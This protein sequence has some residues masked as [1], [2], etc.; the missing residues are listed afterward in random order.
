MPEDA[1]AQ[2]LRLRRLNEEQVAELLTCEETKE[3]LAF[4]SKKVKATMNVADEPVLE[5]TKRQ[6]MLY[7]RDAF[8][9]FVFFGLLDNSIMLICGD[10]FDYHLGLMFGISTLTAAALGNIVGDCAGIWL[11]G[12]VEAVVAKLRL[13]EHGF[14][15]EQRRITKAQLIKSVGMTSGILVG[16]VLGMFPLIWPEEL[17]LWS[18]RIPDNQ[19]PER[20]MSE[21][22]QYT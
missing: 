13:E 4:L 17:R 16:C 5:P 18:P 22:P 9:P 2:L 15:V 14:S 19:P 10:F 21:C 3:A 7:Y 8:I 11:T 20:K 12:T 6:Y 1:E